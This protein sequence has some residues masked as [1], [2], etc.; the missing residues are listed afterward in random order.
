MGKIIKIVIGIFAAVVLLGVLAVGIL[1]ALFDPNDYKPEIEALAK[2]KAQIDLSI[3]GEIDWSFYPWLGLSIADV[4]VRFVDQPDLAK[5]KKAQLAVNIPSL[6]SGKVQMDSI[7][8]DGLT[9]NLTKNKDG[10]VNWEK[11]TADSVQANTTPVSTDTSP[12]NT[13]GSTQPLSLDIQSISI[14]NGTVTYLDQQAQQQITL[15]DLVINS[16]QISDGKAFP[17]DIVTNLVQQKNTQQTL[18]A[19]IAATANITLDLDNQQY[20]VEGFNSDITLEAEK[21]IKLHIESNLVADLAQN[22]IAIDKWVAQLTNLKASG[23]LT[24]ENLDTLQM[25]G[26]IKTD[27][28]A[29]NSLLEELGLPIINTS[30][31]SAFNKMSIASQFTG[32]A[33]KITTNSLAITIDDTKLNG[34]ANYALDTGR[35]EIALSGNSINIDRYLPPTNTSGGE[36]KSITD[37]SDAKDNGYSKEAVIP[38]DS[39]KP[40]NM[41]ASLKMQSVTY[42]K[43]P[44]SNLDVAIDAR[45]GLIKL[46]KANLSMYSGSIN[47]SATLDVRKTP[48]SLAINKKINGLQL[49]DMLTALNGSAPITGAMS[50]NAAITAKG[51]SVYDIVNSLNG[52]ANISLQNGVIKGIDMAQQLCQTMNN[53]SALGQLSTAESVDGST[54]FAKM[55]G[56]FT[57]KNGVISNGDL[58]ASL[59]AMTLSG[60]GDV[61]LP[62]R[63]LNYG[64]GL[65][66]KENL[67]KQSC[68]VNNKLEG[69]EWPVLCKGSFN[70]A[71]AKLCKP[72]T[73]AIKDMLKAALTDKVKNKVKDEVKSKVEDKLKEKLGGEESVKG[74]LKGLF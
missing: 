14:K 34:S 51:V 3:D 20:V 65:L 72:D 38:V 8:I 19:K 61:N 6:L 17:V 22:R 54:P 36:A 24:I 33:K 40:L 39:L 23:A 41:G 1:T 13:N 45:N 30:D 46:T 4:D 2:D 32:D 5:L 68:S 73:N 26:S 29:L 11:P 66:I 43:M 52:T 71:P 37:S 50:T 57:I 53:L 16:G 15:S 42:N 10:K 44:M 18:A 27:T 63:T 69:V 62:K 31:S 35:P 48:A 28:F 49:G 74:L 21:L 60:K 58:N 70:E 64:L 25:V 55:G 7:L 56:N 9:L 67:F 47:T 59:D 12:E